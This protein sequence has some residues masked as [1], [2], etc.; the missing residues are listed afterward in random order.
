[1]S[2]MVQYL[3]KNINILGL[4]FCVYIFLGIL[5]LPGGVG[6][7]LDPS[8]SYGIS[9]AVENHLVFGKDII[10]TYGPLGYLINGVVLKENFYRIFLFRL[11]IQIITFSI[12]V[13][14]I[15]LQKNTPQKLLLLV[16]IIF[17]YLLGLTIDYEIIFSLLMMLSWDNFIT[18]KNIRL[19]ALALGS[20][21]G[22]LLLAKFNIGVS[23]LGVTFL[24]ILA[25]VFQAFQAKSDLSN[26]LFAIADFILAVL[27][28]SFLFINPNFVENLKYV[29]LCIFL[30]ILLGMMMEVMRNSKLNFL[31]MNQVSKHFS[32]KIRFKNI[33]YLVYALGIL[34]VNFYL[35]S[36]LREFFKGSIEISSG[37]SSAMSVVGSQ[38]ELGVAILGLILVSLTLLNLQV[39]DLGLQLAIAFILW[40]SFKH[41][42]VRQDGH[43][44]TFLQSLIILGSLVVIKINNRAKLL[45]ILTLIYLL[46]VVSIYSLSSSPFGNSTSYLGNRLEW[47]I[48]INIFNKVSAIFNPEKLRLNIANDSN[49]NLSKV[50][51]PDRVTQVLSN[52]KVD[53]IPWEISLV[54]SNKLNWQ[55][56]PIFQSYSAY[57]KFLDQTNF[58]HVSSKSPDYILYQ[59]AAIDNRHPFF[60]EPSTFSYVTCNY[61]V[62]SDLKQ[63]V[64]TPAL[65]GLIIL[66]KRNTSICSSSIGSQEISLKWN[67]AVKIPD[68]TLL[69]RAS[70]KFEYSLLGK[71][72]KTIFRSPPV[73]IDVEFKSGS[74]NSYRI[75]PENSE[76][77]I[78][79]SYLPVNTSQAFSFFQG[80][81]S[82]AVKSVKFSRDNSLLYK[83]NIYVKFDSYNLDTS[84]SDVSLSLPKLDEITFLN[85]PTEEYIGSFDTQK[86]DYRKEDV[87]TLNGWVVLKSNPQQSIFILVT[88]GEKNIP[89]SITQTGDIRMDV[90]DYY[91]NQIYNKSGWSTSLLLNHTNSNSHLIKTWIYDPVTK[92]AKHLKGKYNLTIN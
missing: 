71:I 56:R 42:Y 1:M 60:D 73:K 25:K 86:V 77:G 9:R 81:W 50:R 5:S 53:I 4:F 36:Q 24:V 57:T 33:F 8:W 85:Q 12:I 44:Y 84:I 78:I 19:C 11:I 20:I 54:E 51:L 64:D 41:G 16:S 34:I 40:M 65:D 83:S 79:M 6:V 46:V 29:L 26:S 80:K 52:K 89:I 37:Y 17:S 61:Q 15:S 31:D 59:F 67:E 3:K 14:T 68:F 7:G 91:K 88:E 43:V 21:S 76:N 58:S 72:Y 82:Q 74:H 18:Q 49:L 28:S 45:K 32:D 27:T 30:G 39:E 38:W 69:T 35:T 90:G 63:L 22:F 87:I 48:P 47:F 62:S 55:P 70:I 2:N 66:Q 23:L 10:F 92:T 75:I 13:K